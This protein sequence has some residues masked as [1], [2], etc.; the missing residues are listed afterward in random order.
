MNIDGR[1]NYHGLEQIY[2]SRTIPR[3]QKIRDLKEFEWQQ[4]DAYHTYER[5]EVKNS[6]LGEGE[7]EINLGFEI[8]RGWERF[9]TIFL[10]FQLIMLSEREMREEIWLERESKGEMFY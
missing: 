3:N 4:S 7:V 1:M 10:C 5:N 8:Q 9:E 2:L 6:G